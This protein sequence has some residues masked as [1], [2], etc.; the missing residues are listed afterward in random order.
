VAGIV[1]FGFMAIPYEANA[2]QRRSG[3]S[4]LRCLKRSPRHDLFWR[5]MDRK[6]LLRMQPRT[7]TSLTSMCV[8]QWSWR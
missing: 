8:G 1:L 3:T 6:S 5:L 2:I 4:L 7:T